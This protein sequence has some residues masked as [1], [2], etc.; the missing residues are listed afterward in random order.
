MKKTFSALLVFAFLALSPVAMAVGFTDLASN[1]PNYVAIST[2]VEDGTLVGFGDGTFR[3]EDPVTRAQAVKILLV[4]LDKEVK[5]SGFSSSFSDVK[6]SDW[7]YKYVG[8]G[9]D[10]GMIQGYPDGSFQPNAQVNLAEASAMMFKAAGVDLGSAGSGSWFEPLASYAQKWNIRAVRGDGQWHPEQVLTR[11]EMAEMLVRLRQ[12]QSTGKAFDDSVLWPRVNFSDLGFSLKLPF[13]W[14]Y[15][16]GGFGMAWHLDAG[17]W[18]K[19]P[20]ELAANSATIY[21][22]PV[23]A[24]ENMAFD[25]DFA[26][27]PAQ[28]VEASGDVFEEWFVQ[29]A[30]GKVVHLKTLRGKGLYRAEL[31]RQLGAILDSFEVLSGASLGDS[32]LLEALRSAIQVDG[33]GKQLLDL[34]TDKTLF[35]TDTIGVGTGPVDYYY[36]KNLNVTIKYERSFDVILDLHEGET[37]AF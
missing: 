27:L 32:E 17:S 20:L 9:A 5:E 21:L 36:S 14:E 30:D 13:D 12:V 10:S 37:S 8:S 33:A 19:S 22:A 18:Q 31:E 4:G 6:S 7:F 11:G 26:G 16:S 1:H 15:E 34:V 29:I 2:L 23:L 24:H 3:P 25:S 28:S 35:E